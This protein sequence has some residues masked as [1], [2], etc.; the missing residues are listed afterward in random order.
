[1][2]AAD[3][4]EVIAFWFGTLDEAGFAAPAFVARWFKP[5][6]AF[7]DEIRRRFGALHARLATEAEGWL[8]EPRGVLAYVLVLDQF[9]RNAFRNTAQMYAYDARALAAAR[10]CVDAGGDRA[11]AVHERTFLYLPFMHSE[12]LADQE[13]C[14]RLF[15]DLADELLG[16]AKAKIEY[17]HQYAVRHRD[18]VARFGRFPHR[19]ALL[20]R[21]STADEAAFL[22]EP[23][24]SF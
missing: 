22:L 17:N 13:R 24:S 9:S 18:I 21:L 7:D 20:G 1:M 6:V 2:N 19:N 3:V 23:G 12:S 11:L 10:A 16:E 15:R 5:D 4:S 14:V 8:D